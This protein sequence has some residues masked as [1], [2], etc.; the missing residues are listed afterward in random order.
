MTAVLASL[1]SGVDLSSE[2]VSDLPLKEFVGLIWIGENP[3][4][5]L[6]VVARSLEEARAQVIAEHGESHVISL[7]NEDDALRPRSPETTD[8]STGA[9]APPNDSP[10]E[11]SSCGAG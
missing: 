1:G 5:R 9:D 3:G 4:L 2:D 11:G 8:G 7:W 6:R 10:G